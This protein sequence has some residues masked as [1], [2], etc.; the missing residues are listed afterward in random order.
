MLIVAN[1]LGT[2]AWVAAAVVGALALWAA[3]LSSAVAI[4]GRDLPVV[5]IMAT[6]I[7]AMVG[8]RLLGGE[9]MAVAAAVA[10]IAPMSW[11]VM[12]ESSRLLTS[13]APTVLVSMLAGL[14]TASL[15]Q[16]RFLYDTKVFGVFLVVAGAATIA[17]GLTERLRTMPFGDPFT[18]SALVAIASSVVA[19]AVWDLS[20]ATY[21]FAGVVLAVGLV[22][23]RTLG[24]II[25][26][27]S[28]SLVD[29]PPGL[30]FP[31]DGVVAAATLYLPILALLN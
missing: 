29:R 25:R 10:V 12:S 18:I 30:A 13:I 27:G 8:T 17:S 14:A 16:V 15:L 20:L 5:P 24:S 21:L 3:D 23:G 11:G 1:V 19:A 4:R 28:S 22:A 9:G 6:T 26:T 2:E 31:T 7:A